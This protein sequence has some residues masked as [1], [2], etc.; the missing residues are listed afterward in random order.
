MADDDEVT[1]IVR[2]IPGKPGPRGAPGQRGERG[3]KGY[4]GLP[5]EPGPPGAAGAIG[6]PGPAG[7]APYEHV[8]A[9]PSD[10]WIVNH[11]LGRAP[12]AVRLVTTGGVEFDAEIVHVSANEV[13]VYLAA[14]AIGRVYVC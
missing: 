8:Q 3:P 5:G 9:T 10:T 2:T 14:P 7:G 1:V 4:D 12:G 11:N 6:P 13:R